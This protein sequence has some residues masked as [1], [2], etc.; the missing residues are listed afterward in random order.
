[1]AT[2]DSPAPRLIV[3]LDS[4]DAAAALALAARLDPRRCAVKVGKELFVAAGPQ[5]VREIVARGFNV[6]LDLKFHDIPNTVAGACAAAAR[7]GAWMI[8]VHAAG[9]RAM[10]AAARK[11]ID[12]DARTTGR[13][14]PLLVAVTVLTSL[15]AAALA[16]TGVAEPPVRQ[17]LRLA[18]LAR[19]CGLDGV[20]C[21]AQ[22]APELRAAFGTSFTL[23]TPGI[24]PAGAPSADQARV[25]T[26]AD[27]VARGADYLVIGRP[28]T[29]AP[30]P[31]AALAA[32]DASLGDSR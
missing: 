4:A 1:M 19:E 28:I 22:E 25:V 3:A 27:A 17:A 29:A 11:A 20:V 9:G 32:I 14:P 6:F 21:S 15:D 30:D 16:E 31:L 2:P 26:P 24:R 13:S 7:L 23:V 5:V 8:D 10:L 12:D 18:R